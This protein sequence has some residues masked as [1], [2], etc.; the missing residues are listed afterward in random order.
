M[1]VLNNNKKLP[2][3]ETTSTKRAKNNF[4]CK[5][6]N[7]ATSSQ[8]DRFDLLISVLFKGC[9][10]SWG[11]AWWT[12]SQHHRTRGT[13]YIVSFRGAFK[14]YTHAAE[15]SL[16]LNNLWAKSAW[17]EIHF[18][19]KAARWRKRN[20]RKCIKSKL[21]ERW[22]TRNAFCFFFAL[23]I[24]PGNLMMCF[25]FST[26]CFRFFCCLL[27]GLSFEIFFLI[28][29]YDTLDG[30]TFTSYT[31]RSGGRRRRETHVGDPK[32]S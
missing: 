15:S 28:Q 8:T 27:S 21:D 1:I 13:S 7:I 32:F 30:G 29:N 3:N 9:D 16:E 11:I 19:L 31:V 10:S 12:H 24:C 18:G 6:V 4:S 23:T 14:P 17:I 25:E 2:K 26:K 5:S 20:V 22:K